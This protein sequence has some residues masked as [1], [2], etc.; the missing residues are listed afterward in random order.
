MAHYERETTSN[1]E[2]M[3]LGLITLLKQFLYYAK[4]QNIQNYSI[5]YEKFTSGMRERVYQ[6]CKFHTAKP[7][8]GFSLDAVI[9][10]IKNGDPI[11]EPVLQFADFWTHIPF[12]QERSYLDIR[13]WARQYC[14]IDSD[15]YAGNVA[16][17]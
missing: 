12:L 11:K 14:R 17:R 6:D 9:N 2:P 7:I 15:G 13:G 3:T 5:I 8:H 16:I 4:E 1:I 10:S